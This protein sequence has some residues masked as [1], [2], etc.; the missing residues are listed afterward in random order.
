MERMQAHGW[1]E[2]MLFARFAGQQ[3]VVRTLAWPGDEITVQP[4]PSIQFAAVT[5]QPKRVLARE[6]V[7]SRLGMDAPPLCRVLTPFASPLAASASVLQHGP[8]RRREVAKAVA[9]LAEVTEAGPRQMIGH[10]RGAA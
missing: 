1:F 9:L 8:Y 5:T 2:G 7:M 3:P 10:G 6:R 4:R